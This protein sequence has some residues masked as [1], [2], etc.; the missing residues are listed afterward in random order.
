[1][2]A[3][4]LGNL[5]FPAECAVS[6]DYTVGSDH[7]GLLLS[8]PTTHAPSLP[9]TPLGWKID[10]LLHDAWAAH[11]CSLPLPVITNVPSLRTAAA[12]LLTDLISSSDAVFAPKSPPSSQGFAWWDDLC[13]TALADLH[14]THGDERQLKVHC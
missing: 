10:P 6:F 14:H 12:Q 9:P 5:L 8:L 11:F 4:F 13:R 3:A 2:N 7:A 1:M